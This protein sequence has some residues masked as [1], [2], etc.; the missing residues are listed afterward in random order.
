MEYSRQLV[1]RGCKLLVVT[2]RTGALPEEVSREFTSHGCRVV[3]LK[4][5][6]ADA[7]NM[8]QIMSSLREELPYIQH[9]AHA[10]GVSGFDMLQDMGVEQFWTVADAKVVGAPIAGTRLPLETEVLFS[11]T[12]AVWSQTGAAHYAAA[13]M[14]LDGHASGRQHR[15]LPATS[16]QLGPFAEAGMA[17]GHVSELA[18]IGLKGLTPK[19]LQDAVLVAGNA[20]SSVYARIDAP[21]FVQLYT[22]KGRWS[23][24]DT[25][26]QTSPESLL[27]HH[28]PTTTAPSTTFGTHITSQKASVSIDS[29]AGVIKKAAKDILGD[30][31]EDFDEFP[32]G[33]FDSLSAVELSSTVGTELGIQLPGTLVYDYPS[34]TS[35]AQHV[36]TLI[37]PPPSSSSSTSVALTSAS[38]APTLPMAYS[39][40]AVEYLEVTVASRVAQPSH[41]HRFSTL[42]ADAISAVPFGR[43]NLETLRVSSSILFQC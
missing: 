34:V 26:L 17:A 35:M 30:V 4:A 2:S 40:N 11:S 1:R 13:N 16:L 33:G 21:R 23:L 24:V 15:G 14:F 9:Y 10:A 37:A 3:A 42:H 31:D 43:W 12:S 27:H 29:V 8:A 19:Q 22:A 18:A 6:A 38:L 41:S 36:F 5:D 28:Q 39:T 7:A 32:A 20:P 25:A